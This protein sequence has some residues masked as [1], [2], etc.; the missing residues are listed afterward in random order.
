MATLNFTPERARWVAHERWHPKQ[1]SRVLKDGSY[2]LKVPFSDDR[3]LIMDVLKYG[4]D[5]EVVS[6]KPLREK[7]EAELARAGMRYQA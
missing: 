2:E 4:S 7:V 1:E 5:C 3:E 6:P